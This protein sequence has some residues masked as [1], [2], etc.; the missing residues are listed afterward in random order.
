[1]ARA[2]IIFSKRCGIEVL[3]IVVDIEKLQ[4]LPAFLG[5][6]GGALGRDVSQKIRWR[7]RGREGLR[8]SP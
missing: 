8:S 6:G 2:V 3:V 5:G 7:N 1:M 4:C